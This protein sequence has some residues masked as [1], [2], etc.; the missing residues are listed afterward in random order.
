MNDDSLRAYVEG[1]ACTRGEGGYQ[2]CYSAE[3]EIRIY[4]TGIWQDMDIWRGL[5]KLKVP[6]LIIRGAETDTFWERTG[7]LVKRKQP[8]VKV[9]ALEKSTHLVALERPNK[10]SNLIHSFFEENV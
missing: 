1:I 9:E 5:P 4:L 10:V 8:K 3:W 6:M 2:L 7:K